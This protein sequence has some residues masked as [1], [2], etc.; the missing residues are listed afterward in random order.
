V[1][2]VVSTHAENIPLLAKILA[3]NMPPGVQKEA[4][5]PKVARAVATTSEYVT[6]PP[7]V[8]RPIMS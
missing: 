8:Y 6:T 3:E 2:K 4:I 7:T 1:A 5:K